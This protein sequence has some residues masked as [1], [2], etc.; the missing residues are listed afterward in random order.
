MAYVK[1]FY[2]AKLTKFQLLDRNKV[3][4]FNREGPKG[5][6]TVSIPMNRPAKELLQRQ[7][8][9]RDERYPDSL[10]LFPGQNGK[11]RT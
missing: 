8:K 4:I 6:K 5:G 1:N 2:K 10:Y 7:I 3:T 11:L 9:W